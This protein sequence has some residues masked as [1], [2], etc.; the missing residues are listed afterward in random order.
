MV[1]LAGW[2][3]AP[4][5]R[6]GFTVV[7]ASHE[8]VAAAVV[9]PLTNP[10]V[11]PRLVHAA[12]DEARVR[13]CEVVVL[14]FVDTNDDEGLRSIMATSRVNLVS[15]DTVD[16]PLEHTVGYCES[17][18]AGLLVIHAESIPDLDPKLARRVFRGT[19]D[20]LVVADEA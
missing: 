7:A 15:V 6:R 5:P 9:V 18:E 13:I 20:V 8:E 19:F 2:R 3:S 17:I 1:T 10:G 16:S 14:E 11:A 4:T 12:L